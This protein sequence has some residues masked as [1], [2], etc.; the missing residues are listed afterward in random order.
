M[1]CRWR[2][3]KQYTLMSSCLDDG[4]RPPVQESW[5]AFALMMRA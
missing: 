2:E 1:P 4:R 5:A 3:A